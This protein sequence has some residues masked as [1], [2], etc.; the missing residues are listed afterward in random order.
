MLLSISPTFDFS[1]IDWKV[2]IGMV[3][4]LIAAFGLVYFQWWRNRKRLSYEIVSNVLLISTEKGIEDKVEIR[5]EGQVVRNVRLIVIKL[6]NDG[7]LSIKRD[8]F[9]KPIKFIFPGAKI[10]T[11]EKVKF[12]PENLGTQM[13]YRD[14]WIEMDP[15]L[16]NRKD[17]VQFKV[18][19]SGYEKMIID[20]R[21][22][23]VAAIRKS[24]LLPP[25]IDAIVPASFM[26][27][28]FLLIRA[29]PESGAAQIPIAILLIMI[30]L[31]YTAIGL[32]NW[33]KS[34]MLPESPDK[35]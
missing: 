12:H 16:L 15:T 25:G 29:R 6:I 11:S 3:A 33:A 8:D 17:Y 26:I 2:I 34:R 1:T 19:L 35:E 21:I 18:L 27:G 14:D 9:E 31:A 20:A 22:V 28:L 24:K 7:Y 32:I 10:L 5:Y 23:G 4:V 13:A 30:I